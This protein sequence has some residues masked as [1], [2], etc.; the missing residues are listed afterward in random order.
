MRGSG[1]PTAHVSREGDARNDD[2]LVG[3]PSAGSLSKRGTAPAAIQTHL[4]MPRT[5]RLPRRSTAPSIKQVQAVQRVV[6]WYFRTAFGRWEGPGVLP[7]YCD[8]Q[9]VGHFAVDQAQLAAAQP[10]ALFRLLVMLSMYQGRRD[11][12]L[13]AQQRQM[14]RQAV[15]LLTSRTVLSRRVARSQC[16]WLRP[17]ADFER[18]CTVAKVG[19]EVDC[20]ERPGRDC[21]VK[22]ASAVLGR[23]GD[24]G[25]LPTSAWR[26]LG[27]GTAFTRLLDDVRAAASESGQRARLAVDRLTAVWRIGRKLA[28]LYV[29]ILSTP[30]LAPGLSPWHPHLDGH[31]LVVIDSNVQ[32]LVDALRGT[33]SVRTYGA[34]EAWIRSISARID[35]TQFASSMPSYSPRIV[36]QALYWFGSRSNRIAYGDPCTARGCGDC[37]RTLC[38]FSNQ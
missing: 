34:R 20:K 30:Q 29:S 4:R 24:M 7:F 23:M 17:A 21:H 12:L 19:F 15:A 22:E 26:Q 6:R 32:R 35:L 14:S 33:A 10:N 5:L 3:R 9:R 11:S 28:T 13:M 27:H 36:Q 37:D 25:K 1:T 38:P 16:Q 18:G 8:A 31:E 2:R